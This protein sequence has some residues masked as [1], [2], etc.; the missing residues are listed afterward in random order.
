MWGYVYT[1]AGKVFVSLQ[2]LSVVAIGQITTTFLISWSA[3]NSLL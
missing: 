1:K 2:E 3:D